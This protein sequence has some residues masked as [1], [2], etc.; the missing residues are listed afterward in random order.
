M[1]LKK[2]EKVESPFFGNYYCM[3][4]NTN[5]AFVVISKNACTF[6]KKVAIYNN[7]KKWTPDIPNVWEA[8]RKVG[9]Y[10]KRSEYLFTAKQLKK[11][12]KQQ[13]KKIHKFAVWR[14][15]IDRVISTYKLF[16]LEREYRAYFSILN[17]YEDDSFSRFMEFIEF[18]L[19]KSDP[20]HIDEH[21][22]KQVDYY[23]M[24]HIDDVV[25]INDLY[26]YLEAHKISFIKEVSNKT[27]V[28]FKIKNI[29]YL[30]KIKAFYKEDYL[31]K[32]TWRT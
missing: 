10:P 16:V 18:E 19:K 17:L 27:K 11:I 4:P 1:R 26:S 24:K 13:N 8:H 14:D 5:Y 30:N 29:D 22:R 12:E 9:S 32:T 28:N 2:D 31:I 3:I 15:P 7:E 23:S 20:L 25:H 6:L 21:I